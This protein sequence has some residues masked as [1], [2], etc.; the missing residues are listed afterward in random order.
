MADIIADFIGH[1]EPNATRSRHHMADGDIDI[2]R[3]TLLAHHYQLGEE[4]GSGGFATIF[5]AL[6]LGYQEVF[7]VKIM[8][9]QDGLD[10]STEITNLVRLLHPHIIKL[11][12][13][14]QDDRLFYIVMEYC[15]GGNL[16]AKVMAE[17]P[18]SFS[19]FQPIAEQ[20]LNAVSHC[21]SMGIAH[22]DIKPVNVF[23]DSYGR[24][25]LADFGLS[26][27]VNA[28][29][30]FGG[31][32]PYMAPE[33]VMKQRGFDPTKSDI[34]SLGVTFFFC[35]AG[36][37]PWQ[38]TDPEKL[39]DEIKLGCVIVPPHVD[40]RIGTMITQMVRVDPDRRASLS[41]LRQTVSQ[42]SGQ[43]QIAKSVSLPV[44]PN[45]RLRVGTRRRTDRHYSFF[46]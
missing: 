42:P 44:W 30:S 18:L 45:L 28:E 36:A 19:D 22:L 43:G 10:S 6:H 46:E 23:F 13:T 25:R 20:L 29:S 31:S 17:G 21:H 35:S 9:L 4:I 11:Y 40:P 24:V 26:R 14:F 15:S 2:A 8:D 12:D 27:A 7:A 34:W 1:S 37:L 33:I 5:T 3:A 38:N 39:C 32:I 41:S 16:K